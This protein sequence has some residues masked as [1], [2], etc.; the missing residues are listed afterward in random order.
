MPSPYQ[1]LIVEF[2]GCTP[3]EAPKV[4]R[5]MRDTYRTLDGIDRRT[6]KREAKLSLAAVRADTEN[7]WGS[8]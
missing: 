3:E 6:F 8:P 2:T 1:K 5:C 4:E 7:L